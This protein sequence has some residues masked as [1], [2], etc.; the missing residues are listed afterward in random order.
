MHISMNIIFIKLMVTSSVQGIY[1]FLTR[2]LLMI[3]NECVILINQYT[4]TNETF[5]GTLGIRATKLAVTRAG[6]TSHPMTVGYR[7]QWNLIVHKTFLIA[8]LKKTVTLIVNNSMAWQNVMQNDQLAIQ[9]VLPY[10]SVFCR[11]SPQ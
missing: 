1:I 6:Q 9:V 11:T 2:K 3:V 5:Q 7:G 4:S 8:G 10:T